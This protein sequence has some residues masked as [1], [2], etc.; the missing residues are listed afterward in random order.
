MTI[1]TSRKSEAKIETDKSEAELVDDARNGSEFAVRELVRRLNPRL[2]RVAR[3]IV[4]TDAEAEDALQ[5]AYMSAFSKLDSFQER[6]SFSTWVTR[7]VINASRM[8]RRRI[9]SEEVYDTVEE[10]HQSRVLTFP[11]QNAELPDAALGRAQLRGLLETAVSELPPDMRLPFL[12]R[13]SEDMSVT[14]IA[15]ELQI[16]PITEKTRLFRA[17]LRLRSALERKVRGG[18]ET[19]FPFG[20]TRCANMASRVIGCLRADG[21]L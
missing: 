13:E 20:G 6:A 19:I 18:F 3:G 4:D 16:N 5:E 17:R 2:F 21:K 11:G 15:R 9:R 8:Q 1:G 14:A 12:L 7:I 10:P